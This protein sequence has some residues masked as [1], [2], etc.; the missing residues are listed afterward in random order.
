MAEEEAGLLER[1]STRRVLQPAHQLAAV[2]VA[3]HLGFRLLQAAGGWRGGC[4]QGR[5]RTRGPR[6]PHR[7]LTPA[8]RPRLAAHRHCGVLPRRRQPCCPPRRPLRR[9]RQRRRPRR[10]QRRRPCP[11]RRQCRRHRPR[12]ARHPRCFCF[13]RRRR[14]P[15]GQQRSRHPPNPPLGTPPPPPPAAPPPRQQAEPTL[16]AARPCQHQAAPTP[17]A[18]P[19]LRPGLPPEALP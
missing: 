2:L 14:S 10:C 7:G 3:A 18:H 19:L 8:P 5:C 4:A 17:P 16:S 9:R 15:L 13:C 12:C 11:R 6:R 1:R